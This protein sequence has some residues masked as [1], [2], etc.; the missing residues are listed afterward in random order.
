METQNTH[1]SEKNLWILVNL[2]NN[3]SSVL[4]SLS[5]SQPSKDESRLLTLR[6]T[7]NVII[8]C[9]QQTFISRHTKVFEIGVFK[10]GY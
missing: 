2:H 5:S 3:I 1:K 8:F 9:N 6:L 4:C 10:L 7:S